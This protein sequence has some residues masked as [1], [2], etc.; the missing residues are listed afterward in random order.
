MTGEG[1]RAQLGNLSVDA[2]LTKPLDLQKFIEVVQKLSRFWQEDMI[3][4]S[5]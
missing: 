4:P 5:S 2:F 1:E 3:L